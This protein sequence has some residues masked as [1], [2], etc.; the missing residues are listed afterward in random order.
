MVKLI[1]NAT[2]YTPKYIGKKDILILNGKIA[3]I[4]EGIN[5]DNFPLDIQM[6]DFSGKIVVPGFIDGH[7]H[8]TGGGGEGDFSTRT[9]EI[10]LRQL[11][12]GGIT[13]V[14]GCLGTD[15][16]TRSLEN[17]YAKAKSLSKEGINAFIYTGSYA[18]P[19]VTFT[20]SIAKD[21]VLID[22][23]I[24]VGEIAISDHRS[25]QP[26]LEEIKKIVSNARL[27]GLISGKAGIVN[28]HVGSG[29]F[30]IDYLF[31]I[32]KDTEIPITNLYPTHMNRNK[33][34]L[35]QG[36]EFAK[37]GG[38]F[39]LTTS[40]STNE[41]K[42]RTVN[43]LMEC[44]KS[45]VIDRVTLTSDGQGSLPKFDKDGNF[46]GLQIGEV[47]SLY[48]IVKTSVKK[49]YLPLEEALKTI[50]VNPSRVLKLKFKGRLEKGYDADLVVLNENLEID[51]VVSCGDFLMYKEK[52][53]KKSTFED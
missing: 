5:I 1:K 11:I 49:G 52:I 24:G 42:I 9:P 12:K 51:S 19:P 45:K 41:D 50:T 32:V 3:I 18:V 40:F 2:V 15:G 16:I 46:I 10:N 8:I 35:E 14:V 13:T 48:E 33:K 25:T 17:L 28:F 47:T 44:Y 22:R 31:D 26:T 21:I 6:Y 39:D 34:L 37:M 29:K 43:Y 30:G 38:F 20:G 23:V 7:V 27:G 53:V 36:I 4:E